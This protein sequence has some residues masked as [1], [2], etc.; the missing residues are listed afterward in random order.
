ML[1]FSVSSAVLSKSPGNGLRNVEISGRDS[2]VYRCYK[3][4]EE[5]YFS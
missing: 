1:Q 2:L 3:H 4:Q 5:H